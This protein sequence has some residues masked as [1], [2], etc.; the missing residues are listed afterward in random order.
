MK[1]L[2]QEKVL[3]L[4]NVNQ[5]AVDIFKN[6]GFKDIE[7]LPT[8]ISEEELMERIPEIAILGV[9]SRTWVKKD[10]IKKAK[11]LSAIGCFIVGVNKVDL[12]ATESAGIPV[13]H[14]PFSSTRSV[15]ELTIGFVFSLFRKIHEKNLGTHDNKWLKKVD[16]QEIRG[17]TIGI[18]GFSN[19]GSQVGLMAENL[20][21]KVIFYDVANVLPLGNAIRKKSVNEILQESD[22]VTIHVPSLP[23]TKGMINDKSLAKMKKGSFLINTS[24]GDIVEEEAICRALDSGQLGGYATDVYANEPKSPDEPLNTPLSKYP[25]AL[26]TPHIGGS[27]KEAQT[28]IGQEVAQKLIDFIETGKTAD[29]IN[30]PRLMLPPHEKTHRILHIHKN[31]PGMLASINDELAKRSINISSQYLQTSKNIGYVVTDIDSKCNNEV[32]ESIK[33]IPHTIKCHVIS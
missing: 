20:G 10:L 7:V 17:K 29:A 14:G 22:I 31:T 19:I 24:R 27:T 9:R 23:S 15:A 16:G 3:F 1:L 18:I 30:F 26:L 5:A 6:A 12:E 32:F 21:M 25:S 28:G 11:K 33:N 8:A 2:K 4:E 13:F